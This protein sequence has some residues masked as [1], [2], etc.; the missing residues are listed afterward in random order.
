MNRNHLLILTGPSCVGK[1]PLVH[2]LARLYPDWMANISPL[3]LY[4]CRR[5]RPGEQD[6]QDYHF[7]SRLN[8][9][10]MH[11]NPRFVAMEVRGDL[12]VLDMEELL[13]QLRRS[14]VLFEGNP[15]IAR[16]L[17][18][19]QRLAQVP[20]RSIF[21]SPLSREELADIE[22]NENAP[23][24]ADAVAEVMRRKLIRR[25]ENQKGE[26]EPE[27]LETIYERSHSAWREIR[28]ASLFDRVVVNHDGEDSDNWSC[29][30]V[31]IGEA[32]QAMEAVHAGLRGRPHLHLESWQAALA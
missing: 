29:A 7:R 26:L 18:A 13:E 27:D 28:M 31:P 25:T 17:Q 21:L 8:L 15:F 20:K 2:A 10:A 9:E 23:P 4:N 22:A 3:V 24:I 5:P 12:Q 19:D 32:R 1:S 30:P 6:G 14:S 16:V 11:D